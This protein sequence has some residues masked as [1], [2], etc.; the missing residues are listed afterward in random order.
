MSGEILDNIRYRVPVDLPYAFNRSDAVLF[1]EKLAYHDDLFFFEVSVVEY[2][3]FGFRKSH[4]AS[5]AF[6][7]LVA[8]DV[9]SLLNDLSCVLLPVVRTV[10]IQTYLVI[11]ICSGHKIDCSVWSI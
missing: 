1:D 10:W 2:R 9:K 3:A 8:F 5:L 7:H 6:K 11:W 4:T